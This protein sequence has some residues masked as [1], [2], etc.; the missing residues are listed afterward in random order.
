[1][2]S[3]CRV[4][5]VILSADPIFLDNPIHC[6]PALSALKSRHCVRREL[7]DPSADN[8]SSFKQRQPINFKVE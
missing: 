5:G 3:K 8:L 4:W 1:M 7:I 6:L 2:I